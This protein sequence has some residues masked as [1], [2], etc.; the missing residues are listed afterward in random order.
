MSSE[1][2]KEYASVMEYYRVH[3]F[4]WNI[5]E[6]IDLFRQFLYVMQFFV[7]FWIKSFLSMYF[8]RNDFSVDETIL[9]NIF[10]WIVLFVNFLFMIPFVAFQSNNRVR[11]PKTKWIS[12]K[13]SIFKCLQLAKVKV[14]DSCKV[15][16][17]DGF[18]IWLQIHHTRI[19]LHLFLNIC[20]NAPVQRVWWA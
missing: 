15:K 2:E 19:F 8:E 20:V 10:K 9:S 3:T 1:Y 5:L 4:Y 12:S 17:G 16:N 7:N 18:K 6:W 11:L 13:K 14:S